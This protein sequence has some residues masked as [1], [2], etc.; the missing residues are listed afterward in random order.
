MF[1]DHSKQH[2]SKTA[3]TAP[4]AFAKFW[5]HSKQHGSKTSSMDQ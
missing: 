2:G 3:D 1:W 4:A 5:D